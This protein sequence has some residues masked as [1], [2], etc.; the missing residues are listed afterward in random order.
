[1]KAIRRAHRRADGG[2]YAQVALSGRAAKRLRDA[3]GGD[4]MTVYRY[5][6][7]VELGRLKTPRGVLVVDE[8][9]MIGTPDLWLLLTLTPVA[10][11]VVLVGDAAQLPPIKAGNPAAVLTAS[12]SVPRV[13]LRLPQ[14]QAPSTGIPQVAEQIREGDLAELPAFDLAAPDRPGVFLWNCQDG[15][16]PGW[17]LAAYQ[18]LVGPPPVNADR[19]A[20]IRLHRS[21]VQVLTMTRRGVAGAIELGDAIERSWMASQP[22]I[23]DW[24]FSVG[25]KLLWTRNAYDHPTGRP[26][27]NGEPETADIMNGALGVIQRSTQKG[28]DVRFDD[29]LLAE[30]TRGDLG[31]V[32]RGWAI[33]VHKAQGSAFEAVLIPVVRCR[34]LDR[35]MIYTA[36]TRAKRVAVLIGDRTRIAQAVAAP[37]PAWGRQQALDVD[38]AVKAARVAV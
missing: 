4:A 6:K 10:V 14:R 9:S 34:L 32:L 1:V 19:N 38:R 37:S 16:V 17:V 20:L 30:M 2:A 15:E 18:A 29:G 36:V 27:A 12:R 31:N 28:A 25:S 35:A 8:F 24:G 3:T 23:H 11:D 33:T 22:R 26:L 7:D 5:L 13:T 21:G